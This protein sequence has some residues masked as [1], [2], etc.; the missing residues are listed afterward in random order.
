MSSFGYFME[1]TEAYDLL[2]AEMAKHMFYQ[3]ALTQLDL[4]VS[5][6]GHGNFISAYRIDVRFSRADKHSGIIQV[7]GAIEYH[8]SGKLHK[9]T[10]VLQ[11]KPPT[12]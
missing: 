10:Q 5:I 6:R 9:L 12:R 7:D 3:T 11:L 1:R 4:T 2:A 8:V